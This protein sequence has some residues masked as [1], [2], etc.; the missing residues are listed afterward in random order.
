MIKKCDINL[1]FLLKLIF[2]PIFYELVLGGG[3]RYLEIGP[4]TVRMLFF[5]LAMLLSLIYYLKKKKI[6]KNVAILIAS[7]TIITCLDA[8]ISIAN[9]VKAELILGDLKPLMFFYMILFFSLV[10]NDVN[11]INKASLIIKRGA[12]ILGIAYIVIITLL[13]L[14]KIDFMSFYTTQN[15]IGEVFFKSD[16]LFFYKGF[17]YLCI[18]FFFFLLQKRWYNNLAA[19]FLFTSIV[20]TLTRGFILFSALIYV[21][22]IFFINKKTLSKLLFFFIGLILIIIVVPFFLETL[23]DKSDSNA[24][25]YVQIDQVLSNVTPLS[26]FIGHGFGVG[27]KIRP[28]GMEISFL[29]I[30]HKQGI[31][32][33]SFW[34]GMFSYI[35]LMYFNIKNEMYKDIALPFLLSV[36]F[37]ILQSG[38]NPF[39]NNPI[40]LS[41]ILITFVVFSKLLELQKRI[42]L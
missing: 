37:I 8:L 33:V 36:V 27:V 11:D 34:L 18:G 23:G 1:L 42:D 39:M 31:L 4:L 25:R 38:T 24:V 28:I 16:S 26:L 40:G 17:L 6:K 7:F 9:G 12:L 22:Y 14:G 15:E 35:F 10:I 13:F 2:V 20:L 21:Y 3:G 29:E 30:F 5:I 32:G 19:L 41:M